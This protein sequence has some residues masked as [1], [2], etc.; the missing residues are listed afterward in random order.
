[1]G[2]K[3]IIMMHYFSHWDIFEDYC[4]YCGKY[5]GKDHKKYGAICNCNRFNKP[6]GIHRSL[7]YSCKKYIRKEVENSGFDSSY[8]LN[9]LENKRTHGEVIWK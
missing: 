6:H 2:R 1:M 4:I 3:S 7:C 9:Y 5:I 8:I